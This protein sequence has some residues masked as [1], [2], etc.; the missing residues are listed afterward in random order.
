LVRVRK[1]IRRPDACLNNKTAERN[2]EEGSIRFSCC[3]SNG[4]RK[5]KGQLHKVFTDS[6]AYRQAGLMPKEFTMK[7]FLIRK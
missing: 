2:E 7:S 6:P 3:R 1:K 4:K 5:E